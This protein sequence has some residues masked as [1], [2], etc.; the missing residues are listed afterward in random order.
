MRHPLHYTR[1]CPLSISKCE[2]KERQCIALHPVT[3]QAYTKNSI[4]RQLL[5]SLTLDSFR[6]FLGTNQWMVNQT[7]WS[8]LSFW[9]FKMWIKVDGLRSKFGLS[10]ASPANHIFLIS[11]M[12]GMIRHACYSA[13]ACYLLQLNMQLQLGMQNHSQGGSDLGNQK[14]YQVPP[15]WQA[16]SYAFLLAL[17]FW[18]LDLNN[19]HVW[20]PQGTILSLLHIRSY[21][22]NATMEGKSYTFL[23]WGI[24]YSLSSQEI[25]IGDSPIVW[26]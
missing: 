11:C 4:N 25:F 12:G 14:W 22:Q 20:T 8:F 2:L 17:S 19:I 26:E 21:E 1:T 16:F 23:F 24:I 10:A 6:L 18:G 15:R 9:D 5:P 7:D 13:T 3:D